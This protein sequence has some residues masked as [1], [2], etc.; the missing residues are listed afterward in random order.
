MAALNKA[1]T[2]TLGHTEVLHRI[3]EGRTNGEITTILGCSFHTSNA[4]TK[5][6]FQRLSIHTHTHTAAL[7]HP[8]LL[9][10]PLP[11]DSSA[12]SPTRFS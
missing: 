11:A 2:L 12:D 8:C 5:E 10:S 3:A 4:P 1:L 9:C 7:R 6:L